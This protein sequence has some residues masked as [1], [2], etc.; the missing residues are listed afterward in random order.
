MF[1]KKISSL[2]FSS[3]RVAWAF[4]T[5]SYFVAHAPNW[6]RYYSDSG[7]FPLEFSHFVFRNSWR[8]S[9]FDVV[10]SDTGVLIVCY[11]FIVSLLCMLIGFLPRLSTIIS[12]I[13][14]FT[15]HERN[16]MILGGG[17]TMMRTIGYLLMISP[18]IYTLSVHRLPKQWRQFKE[19]RTL[20][21]IPTMSI[22]PYRLLLWQYLI[23]YISSGID[24]LL[25]VMWWKEGTAMA[26][27]LHHTHFARIHGGFM[28]TLSI[29]SPFFSRATIIFELCWALLLLPTKPFKKYIPKLLKAFSLKR[30]LL[31]GGLAFHGGI[32]LFMEVGVF[33][34]AMK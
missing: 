22:W 31:L 6:L 1:F 21:P 28:D 34:W 8:F 7:V 13:L 20:L 3:M 30:T 5:L 29:L 14:L 16:L 2:G 4:I 25:G 12:V 17:D 33:P 27:A 19:H 24:K 18:G 11:I 9:L 26:A 32:L 15:F 10:T 23:I